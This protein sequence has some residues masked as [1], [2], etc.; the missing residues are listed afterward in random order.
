VATTYILSRVESGDTGVAV[1]YGSVLILTMLIFT[2]LVQLVTG[3][4]RTD[5]QVKII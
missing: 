3:R 5:K 2:L 4:S 1:A